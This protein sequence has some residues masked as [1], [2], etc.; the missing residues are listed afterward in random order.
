MPRSGWQAGFN[1]VDGNGTLVNEQEY[2]NQIG[3]GGPFI[4]SVTCNPDNALMGAHACPRLW[5]CGPLTVACFQDADCGG[6][7]CIGANPGMNIPGACRCG[8]NGAPTATCPVT[9]LRGDIENPRCVENQMNGL[10]VPGGMAGEFYCIEAYNC[11]PPP[12]RVVDMMTG[13]TNYPEAC[14]F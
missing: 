8:E 6:L 3:M 14:G 9:G 1:D 13:E 4:C 2:C 10:N 5:V 11:F 7:S 12:L